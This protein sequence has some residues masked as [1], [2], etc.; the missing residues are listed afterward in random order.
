MKRKLWVSGIALVLLFTGVAVAKG[1][2]KK[3]DAFFDSFGIQINGQSSSKQASGFIYEGTIYLPIRTMAE[4]LGGEITWDSA[5]RS[6]AID[7]LAPMDDD[8]LTAAN[9]MIYQYVAIEKNQIM[10]NLVSNI[11][12]KSFAG[13]KADLQRLQQ[14]ED[15]SENI[16]DTELQQLIS[17]MVFSGEVMR[18]SLEKNA[19]KDYALAAELFAEAEQEL[20]MLLISKLNQ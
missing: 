8:V 5:D 2:Y 19:G 20:T 12:N 7:F 9:V 17:R 6:V 16:N 15:F 13:I 10:K 11:K 18:S 1:Q 4:T 14:L 3:I